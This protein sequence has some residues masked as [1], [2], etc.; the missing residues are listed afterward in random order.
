M[1]DRLGFTQVQGIGP[2]AFGRASEGF[3]G[4]GNLVGHREAVQSVIVAV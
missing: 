3:L 2:R 4:E 1:S